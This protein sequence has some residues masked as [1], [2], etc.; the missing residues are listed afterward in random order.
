MV[1]HQSRSCN[2]DR[3]SRLG[4]VAK[5]YNIVTVAQR[6]WSTVIVLATLIAKIG[7]TSVLQIPATI[8]GRNDAVWPIA[9][10]ADP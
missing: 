3:G 9:E 4:T 7:R 5:R 8:V 2:L 6:I 1:D 10:V